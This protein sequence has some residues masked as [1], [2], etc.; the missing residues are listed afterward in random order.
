MLALRMRVVVDVK[1]NIQG[2]KSGCGMER[3]GKVGHHGAELNSF[4]P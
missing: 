1:L 4:P 2:V 3:R